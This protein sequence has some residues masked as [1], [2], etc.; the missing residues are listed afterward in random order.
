MHDAELN[1]AEFGGP[2]PALTAVLDVPFVLHFGDFI[3]CGIRA[4][5]RRSRSN[6]ADAFPRLH[7][8]VC[9]RM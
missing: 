2:K 7:V 9:E 5:A 6:N 3:A 4:P 8:A 1:E